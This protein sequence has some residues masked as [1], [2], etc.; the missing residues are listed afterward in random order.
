MSRW[1]VFFAAVPLL[2]VAA[3]VLETWRLPRLDVGVLLCLFG[4]LFAQPRLLPGIVL[5]AALGRALVDE[6]GLA[7]QVLVLGVP[8]AALLPLRVLLVRTRWVW[9]ALLA[10]FLAL[11]LP[12]LAAL[13][14]VWFQ[15]PSASAT[16]SG[17]AV[18]V[19]A[20][21]VPPVLLVLRRVPPLVAFVEAQP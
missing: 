6:A 20:V 12:K 17:S 4:V 16:L 19:A 5:G 13:C 7:V 9:Q 15:Q 11:V 14:G 3:G 18:L 10:A 2:Y 1:L 21:V 8:V